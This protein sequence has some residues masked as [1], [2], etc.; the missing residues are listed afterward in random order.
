VI[1]AHGG[2]LVNRIVTGD[3]K[4]QLKEKAAEMPA[5]KL[6][7][8]ELTAVNN[9]ATGLFSPLEGFMG[10]EDYNSVVEDMRLA[11]GTVWSIPVVL[12]AAQEQASQL[13]EGEDV[14]LYFEEDDELYAILHLEE[15]YKYD[16][17]RKQKKYIQ[18]LKK[19]ILE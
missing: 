2:K 14:A 15:K 4:R 7:F 6:D 19:S 11:D 3:E 5:L 9:I 16:D 18:Q 13:K 10:K 17:K 1:E 12:G 8:D